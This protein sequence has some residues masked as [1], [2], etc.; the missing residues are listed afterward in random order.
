MKF[1]YSIAFMLSILYSASGQEVIL[2]G[3]IIDTLGKPVEFANIMAIP[4]IKEKDIAFFI[5]DEHGSFKLSLK[6]NVLYNIEVSFVGYKKIVYPINLD[7]NSGKDF[8]LE[9]GNESLN[10]VTITEQQIPVTVKDDTINYHVQ[11]FVS[12]DERKLREVLAKLPGVEVDKDGNVT[13]N[14]KKITKLMIEGKTFFTGDTKLGVNNIPADAVADVQVINNYS[15]LSFMKDINGTEQT[16]L[17]IKLKKNKKE[18]IFGDIDAGAGVTSRYIIHPAIFYYS[19]KVS[20]NII[21][22][23][24]NTGI[25]SFTFN[26]Y[27]NFEG[28]FTRL[29]DNPNANINLAGG[30]FAKSLLNNDYIYRKDLFG[31]LNIV[32]ELTPKLKMNLYSIN[33]ASS[34]E[35]ESI[36]TNNYLIDNFS[37]KNELRTTISNSDNFFSLDK[38]EFNY[39]PSSEEN[40]NFGTVLKSSTGNSNDQITSVLST[41]N[42]INTLQSPTSFDL[43]QHIGFNKK[44]SKRHTTTIN[45]DAGFSQ[46]TSNSNWLFSSPVFT[47]I[48]PIK[49]DSSFN[50]LQ[51]I[52]LKNCK[53]SAGIKHLWVINNFNHIYPIIGYNFSQQSYNTTDSQLYNEQAFSFKNAGFD[54]ATLFKFND[55]FAGF[56]YRIKVKKFTFKTGIVYHYYFRNIQQFDSISTT[57]VKPQVL[58]E[59]STKWEK[60]SV[61]SITFNYNLVSR[62]SDISF[63]ANHLRFQGFNSLYRGST[64]LD[65]ELTHQLSF[66]YSKY[67]TFKALSYNFNINYNQ[68]IRSVQ[69]STVLEGIN[70][71]NNSIYSA[72]PDNSTRINGS[73]S[74]NINSIKFTA[75]INTN[76]S[77]YYRYLNNTNTPYQSKTYGYNLKMI[78]SFKNRPNI[79]IGVNQSFTNSISGG[80]ENQY[81][82]VNPFFIFSA[83]FLNNF[84][85]KLDYNYNSLTN[86]STNT[87]NTFQLAH[88]SLR[89]NQEKKPLGCEFEVQNIFDARFKSENTFNQFIIS[90]TQIFIQ[91]RT[92]VFKLIYKI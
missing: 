54:N 2:Q 87:Q 43:S 22:D 13:S 53:F 81:T 76:M 56:Q 55:P 84:N 79:E 92:L 73:I 1:I 80:S 5:S 50:I 9:I 30:D 58:P 27:I 8:V 77:D 67:N 25:R 44:F 48:L 74:K 45:I 26:D 29:F 68:K 59:F 32:Y 90:N 40:Y 63:Y 12:G 17:N 88:A 41:I 47:D 85:F 7:K 34:T 64:D 4:Q 24:N 69:S 86:K 78:T 52:M 39:N 16:A 57:S 11:S 51:N 70:Q 6:K 75:G 10:T 15:E 20:I 38:T 49:G 61:E 66:S 60:S 14:G 37:I 65:N 28:G 89:Y 23:V 91:P 42:S 83:R 31:G 3:K 46:S 71:I 21:G 62:F 82:R 36:N 19:P 33:N 18:F 35:N 72:L